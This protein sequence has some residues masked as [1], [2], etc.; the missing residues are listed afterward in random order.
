M[1]CKYTHMYK[2]KCWLLV[3]NIFPLCVVQKIIYKGASLTLIVTGGLV[4][5]YKYKCFYLV[6]DCSSTSS[7]PMLS[8]IF[9]A[10]A[11]VVHT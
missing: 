5:W 7:I 4:A 1:C 6:V 3:L 10:A 8:F 9:K 11:C 2:Q